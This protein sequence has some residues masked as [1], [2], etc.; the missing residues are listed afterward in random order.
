CRS[1]RLSA[2][3]ALVAIGALFS[4]RSGSE[5]A[6]M[7][8]LA[9]AS[10][11]TEPA[12]GSLTPGLRPNRLSSELSEVDGAR[13]GISGLPAL[14]PTS[15][16]NWPPPD[17]PSVRDRSFEGLGAA[18][19]SGAKG[20]QSSGMPPAAGAEGDGLGARTAGGAGGAPKP[21]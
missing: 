7:L 21:K 16:P 14:A 6:A 17:W 1:D 4:A 15:S 12:S 18:T 2:A 20:S 11:S 5:F 3:V 8:G 10:L 19:G 13:S 9:A